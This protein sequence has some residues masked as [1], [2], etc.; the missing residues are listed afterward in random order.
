MDIDERLRPLLEV[1]DEQYKDLLGS[2]IK[3]H[4]EP[5]IDKI[6]GSKLKVSHKGYSGGSEAGDLDDLCSEARLR[7]IKCLDQMRQEPSDFGIKAFPEFVAKITFNVYN[8]YL[9]IKYP[10]RHSLKKRIYY[11][12][13][14]RSKF[15]IWDEN[16]E[17]V[18]GLELWKN[19]HPSK[20]D[21]TA[22]PEL[23]E[24]RGEY[25]LNSLAGKSPSSI[26]LESLLASLFERTNHPIEI[27]VLVDT[28]A[29][30]LEIKDHPVMEWSAIMH[31]KAGDKR[32]P[33]QATTNQPDTIRQ[34]E[35]RE[36]L[37]LLWSEIK[38][39]PLRQ[40]VALLLSL[41]DEKGNGMINSLTPCG[42][43][44]PLEVAKVLEMK[45]EELKAI[46]N[47]FPLKDTAIA[48][49]LGVTNQQ[50]INLRKTA[51]ERL[52]RRMLPISNKPDLKG[53][54]K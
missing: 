16:K 36:Y 23:Y 34:I 15:D 28:V 41:R 40:R 32:H 25:I 51:R 29:D 46:W 30:L 47:Q 18:A 20:A 11:L 13:K 19:A 53:R 1:D 54:K 31:S 48:Q 50:V 5:L 6:L 27:N 52:A 7:L 39:L 4:A 22:L 3:E 9:R 8:Q 17:K 14:T 38:L 45:R 42:I 10:Q 21:N 44:S 35:L 12:L 37:T 26:P 2:V 43:A 24:D 49:M 33:G